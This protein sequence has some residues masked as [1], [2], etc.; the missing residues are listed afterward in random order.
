MANK[1]DAEECLCV[2]GTKEQD[3]PIMVLTRAVEFVPDV[4]AN[5]TPPNFAGV[6]E[7]AL[8]G[9]VDIFLTAIP[10][11]EVLLHTMA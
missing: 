6:I 5:C 1:T 9:G 11:V 7:R 8:G 2:E 4:D 10:A 3:R